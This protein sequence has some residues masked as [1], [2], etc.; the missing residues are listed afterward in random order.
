[1]QLFGLAPVR[2]PASG[3]ASGATPRISYGPFT[4]PP[5]SL[6]APAITQMSGAGHYLICINISRNLVRIVEF[7]IW[8]EMTCIAK[9]QWQ[10][11]RCRW[12]GASS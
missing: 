10:S 2:L 5:F 12:A 3:E 9:S 4:A 11:S 8:E 1:M 7:I 6:L